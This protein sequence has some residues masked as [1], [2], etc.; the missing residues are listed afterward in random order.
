MR[1]LLLFFAMICLSACQ[2]TGTP[3]KF[4]PQLENAHTYQLSKVN[5]DIE[6]DMIEWE[7]YAN[8]LAAATDKADYRQR[9]LTAPLEAALR[10]KIGEVLIGQIPLNLNVKVKAF[11]I[12]SGKNNITSGALN[13]IT[14]DIKFTNPATNEVVAKVTDFKIG[15]RVQKGLFNKQ[16]GAIH[17]KHTAT[18]IEQLRFDGTIDF[19]SRAVRDWLFLVKR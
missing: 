10:K 5:F 3:K 19:F 11:R 9:R 6:E 14:A 2:T 17:R 7:T 18:S 13:F 1:L 4:I 12:I 8:E 15:H 16:V